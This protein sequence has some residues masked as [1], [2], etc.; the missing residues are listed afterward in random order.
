MKSPAMRIPLHKPTMTARVK[1]RVLAKLK[2]RVQGMSTGREPTSELVSATCQQ[3]TEVNQSANTAVATRNSI[4][5]AKLNLV[6]RVRRPTSVGISSTFSL[7]FSSCQT[8]KWAAAKETTK[9][10]KRGT[11]KTAIPCP[12]ITV[13]GIRVAAYPAVRNLRCSEITSCSVNV[14]RPMG[15]SKTAGMPIYAPSALPTTRKDGKVCCPSLLLEEACN[16]P[17]A[18]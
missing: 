16:S 3:E 5:P 17:K 11:N 12:T 8:R 13:T 10:A 18:S 15:K 2:S 9:L 6:R 4:T 14:I 1:E 7:I